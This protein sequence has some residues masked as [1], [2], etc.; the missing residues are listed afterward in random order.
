MGFSVV[1]TIRNDEL[2]FS[3]HCEV[4]AADFILEYLARL[5]VD[6]IF[7]IP[8]GAIEPLFDAVFRFNRNQYLYGDPGGDPG[9]DMRAM[10]MITSRHEVGAAF[11]A[12]GYAR[13][14]GRLGVCCATTGPGSTNL[15]TGIASAY[16]DR[17]PMLVLTPQTPMATFGQQ[18]FQDSSDDAISIVSM[19]SSCTRYNSVVTHI[20]QLKY[21]LMKAVKM[22]TSHPAGPVHLSLPMDIWKQAVSVELFESLN[23]TQCHQN[24]GY[25]LGGYHE[26]SRL[27][28]Q[29]RKV[30]F[31]LGDECLPHADEIV[32]CAELLGADIITTPAAKG[33][34]RANHPL[35][36]GVLGFAGHQEAERTLLDDGVSYVLAIGAKL[37][38]LEATGLSDNAAIVSKLIYVSHT[39]EEA[40]SFQ[41]AHL[42][43]FGNIGKI[44]HDL[45]HFLFKQTIVHAHSRS[46][47]ETQHYSCNTSSINNIRCVYDEEESTFYD[48]GWLDSGFAKT[49]KP[50]SAAPIKPQYLMRTLPEKLPSAS[51]FHIDA[52]NGW[53]WAT[54]YLHLN[55]TANYRVGMHFGSMGW[56]IGASV[57]AACAQDDSPSV[58]ITGDG[59]YLMSGQEI[60]V[61]VQQNLSV[62]FIVLNDSAY[63]MVMHGQRLNGAESV[64]F[65]L[66]NV[67]FAMMARAVGAKGVTVRNSEELD[68]LD[69]C[70][71]LGE[72][73]PVLIDIHIDPEEVPPMASRIKDLK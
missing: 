17:I 70:T 25:D 4:N 54:H 24:E 68:E 22:A 7:G 11:M 18:P 6:T 61:A 60:T 50:G 23:T 59:S 9:G 20:D 62:V 5:N 21:K 49:E 15:I 72:G 27:I 16:M 8:G 37:G 40:M 31:L 13:E 65:D 51:R 58:C 64:G 44:F 47:T 32:K 73:G 46:M 71:L 3:D 30:L 67:D 38:G 28:G 1:N 35:F 43:L 55:T 42:Q 10:K 63:G 56:A 19:L 29:Q 34:V 48:K 53:A 45:Y 33:C 14:T 57:G 41:G 52:G 66:P 2:F 36:K 26:L 12:D 39:D 69:I